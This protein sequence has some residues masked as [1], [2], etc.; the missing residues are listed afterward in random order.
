MASNNPSKKKKQRVE[1]RYEFEYKE[2]SIYDIPQAVTHLRLHPSVTEVKMNA[3]KEYP[4]LKE[5]VFNEGLQT[6]LA[7]AFLGCDKLTSINIPSTVSYIGYQAFNRCKSLKEVVLHKGLVQIDNDAFQYCSS[8]QSITIP[9][10]V[11][12]IGN[13]AFYSCSRLREVVLNEGITRIGNHA[14]QF[15]PLNTIKLPSTVTEVGECA[16][17]GK[18]LEIVE[19][20]EN[21]P[22]TIQ[23]YALSL[24]ERFK[25]P[26]LSSRLTTIIKAGQVQIVN[27]IREIPDV[28]WREVPPY[29]FETGQ[30]RI[31][32]KNELSVP[33]RARR[34]R[35]TWPLMGM[36]VVAGVDR[37]KLEEV[38]RWIRYYEMKEAT[39]LFELALWKAKIDQRGANDTNRETYR[40]EV[41]GPVKDTI[42]HYL[43]SETD[44][45]WA[46]AG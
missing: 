32:N 33:S 4:N 15:C 13:S 19:F 21:I 37:E 29:I 9:P 17:N 24:V 45:N 2:G 1:K 40:T 39:T 20:D 28:E 6:I 46:G 7:D 31:V 43:Y 36:K 26:D 18:N 27:K 3:F 30:R 38:K 5:V 22:D 11:T 23:R 25:Y 12:E 34:I 42:L 41:P 44:F 16:F 35:N 8:L 10:T 14:F